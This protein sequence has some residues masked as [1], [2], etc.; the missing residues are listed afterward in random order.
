MRRFLFIASMV[1]LA[2]SGVLT[3]G[4]VSKGPVFLNGTQ[5]S[6]GAYIPWDG[7]LYGLELINF[8]T[9][10]YMRFPTNTAFKVDH[11]SNVTNDWA[12]GMMESVSGSK[13]KADAK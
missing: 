1:L 10:T 6:L 5:I 8:T 11:Q 12:W 9:G 2:V 4:C 3:D 7:N 13:T